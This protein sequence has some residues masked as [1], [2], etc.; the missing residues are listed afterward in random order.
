MRPVALLAASLLV[1]GC[2]L[3]PQQEAMPLPAHSFGPDIDAVAWEGIL[4]RDGNCV[5]L[6]GDGFE[7]NILWPAGYGVTGD[8]GVIVR[9]DGTG[10]A[11][12]GDQVVIGGMP[13]DAQVA[14]PG[15]PLR[16]VLELGIIA[17]VNGVD[18]PPPVTPPVPQPPRPTEHPRPR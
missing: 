7:S 14:T 17:R 9:Y 16:H 3:G 15:C 2:V 8:T 10:V 6:D 11:R 4:A 13:T 5:F 18:V 1:A 12:L